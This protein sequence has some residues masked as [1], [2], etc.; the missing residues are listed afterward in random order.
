MIE[1]SQTIQ[2][3]NFCT[4]IMLL[5]DYLKSV[6]RVCQE[7]FKSISRVVLSVSILFQKCFM[8]V[9]KLSKP[10]PGWV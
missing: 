6:S 10:Q 3:G 4:K 1:F 2:L 8:S 9:S 5:L 7:C